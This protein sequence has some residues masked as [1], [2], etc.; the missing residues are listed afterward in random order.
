MWH[1][2]ICEFLLLVWLLIYQ[3]VCLDYRT[4]C[5]VI[6]H[7][8][9]TNCQGRFRIGTFFRNMYFAGFSKKCCFQ[10]LISGH[11]PSEFIFQLPVWPYFLIIGSITILFLFD[12]QYLKIFIALTNCFKNCPKIVG[13]YD[14]RKQIAISLQKT[15]YYLQL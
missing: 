6:A 12:S 2:Y 9:Q 15:F 4:R 5:D 1:N 11:D 13:H 14:S 10:I 7:E 3:C 8:L